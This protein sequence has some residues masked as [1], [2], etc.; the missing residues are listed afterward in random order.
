MNDSSTLF[1]ALDCLEQMPSGVLLCNKEGKILWVNNMMQQLLGESKQ[2][3]LELT[4]HQLPFKEKNLFSSEIFLTPVANSQ[5]R[6][7]VIKQKLSQDQYLLHF[8]DVSDVLKAIKSRTLGMDGRDGDRIDPESA[9]LVRKSVLQ[10]LVFEVSR[11]RRYH[12]PLSIALIQVQEKTSSNWLKQTVEAI[13]EGKRWVDI[14]GRWGENC[15]LLILPE[16]SQQSAIQLT[17]KLTVMLQERHLTTRISV[18]EW[19]L[20]DDAMTLLARSEQSL[21][22]LTRENSASSTIVTN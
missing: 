1:N 8:T 10:K 7:K 11:S 17:E 20:E 14:L 13:Q 15:F 5:L 21:Y 2:F 16:T 19:Q 18:A 22:M 9:V 3:L 12:N 4:I 6:L